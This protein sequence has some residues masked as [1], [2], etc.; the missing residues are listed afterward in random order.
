MFGLVG[1]GE[2]D[3]YVAAAV[4]MLRSWS[5]LRVSELSPAEGQWKLVWMFRNRRLEL[6]RMQGFEMLI[7]LFS[8]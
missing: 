8:C 2:Q 7:L 1:S 6:Y 5:T 4:F 3:V